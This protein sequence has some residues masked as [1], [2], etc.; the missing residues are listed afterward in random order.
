MTS[1]EP[2]K[3]QCRAPHDAVH[4]EC[5]DRVFRAGRCEPAR[6]WKQGRDRQLIAANRENRHSNRRIHCAPRAAATTL[7]AARISS[8]SPLSLTVSAAGRAMTTRSTSAGATSR[9]ARYASR[10][11][12]RARLR[13]TA[14]R[15]CRPTAKPA[16]RVRSLGRQRTI[17]DGRSTRLP[18]WNN[19]WNS[20]P[21]VSRSGRRSRPVT[22]SAVSAPSRVAASE[23]SARPRCS[24]APGT[25]GSS[26]GDAYSADTSVS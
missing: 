13:D 18:C 10:R 9:A 20:V 7:S 6:C 4:G 24:C 15:I 21:L 8:M 1:R 17:I 25:R 3:G 16:R 23:F 5:L 12:R 2:P 19:A 22:L 26:S 11:R 14:P